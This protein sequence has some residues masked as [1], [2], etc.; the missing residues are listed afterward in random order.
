[1]TKEEKSVVIEDLTAQLAANHVIYLADLT[2][3]NAKETSDLRRA[4]FKANIKLAVVKNTFLAKA[5]EASDK[6][7]GD[8]PSVLKGN[9]S[10]MYAEGRSMPA[11]DPVGTFGTYR[12]NTFLGMGD[13]CAH[14]TRCS[15][16]RHSFCTSGLQL[17]NGHVRRG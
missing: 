12:T 13:M 11:F 7:F 14:R 4:C 9:T 3:L 2:G 15:C 17:H 1:M 5:M 6:N 10:V 16:T 8:L